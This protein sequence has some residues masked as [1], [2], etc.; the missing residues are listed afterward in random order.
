M[1]VSGLKPRALVVVTALVATTASGSAVGRATVYVRA[2]GT[3]GGPVEATSC[4]SPRTAMNFAAL[5]GRPAA[6]VDT[7]VLC[8]EGGVF[9]ST[10]VVGSGGSPSA[11]V[12][13]NGRGTA[14][15]SGSDLVTGWRRIGNGVY[16]ATC[17]SRPE[18]LFID[19][20]FGWRQRSTGALDVEGS[21]FWSNGTL[22]LY[23]AKG[24]P[25]TVFRRPGVE[26]GARDY[27]LDLSGSSHV[28]IDGITVRHADE[29]GI[30]AWNP[31]SHVVIR[32]C[33]SEWNW[34]D[35]IHL[36]GRLPYGDITIEF[37]LS[38][39]NGNGGIGFFGPGRNAIIRRNRCEGNGKL[40]SAFQD[41]DDFHQWT[42]G[43]KFWE[44]T[45][46]QEGHLVLGNECLDNGRGRQG[47][48]QGRG[49]GIWIDHV[50]GRLR[51]PIVISGNRV[52]GNAGNGIFI[53]ISSNTKT[54]RNNLVN[55][56]TN[57]G[58]E[59]EY[60]PAGIAIDARGDHVSRNNAVARNVI[61]GGRCGIKVVTYERRSCRVDDNT[62]LRNRVT[63]AAEYALFCGHGGDNDGRH[64]SGNRFDFNVFG[65]DAEGLIGWGGATY[66]DHSSWL[67]AYRRSLTGTPHR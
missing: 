58:G 3:A 20:A 29:S 61:A 43:I 22:Y 45:P 60:V 54:T 51:N 4:S 41:F 47:D 23:T 46:G 14:V 59:A 48:L 32:N 63:G 34:R 26:A 52:A 25:E 15:V 35:G 6:A 27:G 9:R 18:Q 37:N 17:A 16:A 57:T 49:V 30:A 28:V 21:W 24:H 5:S 38:R 8:H 1:K 66:K 11:P 19:G 62:A 64:G 7:I 50:Q 53:E 2:D 40:Q 36:N 10:L 55:N 31:G 33:V 65:D 42:Y 44:E 13:I 39:N 12:T 67:L 56:A